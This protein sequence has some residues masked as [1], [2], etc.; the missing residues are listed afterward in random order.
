MILLDEKGF[1]SMLDFM[2]ET[3]IKSG[4]I[5]QTSPKII[6]KVA[7]NESIILNDAMVHQYIAIRGN[8]SNIVVREIQESDEFNKTQL[9]IQFHTGNSF[10]NISFSDTIYWREG[11]TVQLVNNRWYLIRLTRLPNGGFMG[12]WYEGIKKDME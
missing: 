3:F 1:N 4:E 10:P 9:Y 6:N 7:L 11:K 5:I 2:N 8:V 12:D